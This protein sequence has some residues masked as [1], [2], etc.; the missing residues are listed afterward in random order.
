MEFA[1]NIIF[2]LVSYDSCLPMN[3]ECYD[4]ISRMN[5]LEIIR[6]RFRN[7]VRIGFRIILNAVSI[8]L[9]ELRADLFERAEI[10]KTERSTSETPNYTSEIRRRLLFSLFFFVITV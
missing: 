9:R 3:G 2:A 5:R 7:I 1:W 10:H 6:K 4:I 8:S